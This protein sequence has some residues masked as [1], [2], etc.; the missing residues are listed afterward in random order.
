MWYSAVPCHCSSSTVEHGQ[1]VINSD[2]SS[3][4]TAILVS[5]RHL[6]QNIVVDG[7]NRKATCGQIQGD[8]EC[9]ELWCQLN[10]YITFGLG[11]RK[12]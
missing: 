7:R 11:L 5:L 6:A 1:P 4:D 2:F 3:N 8:Y 10:A 9:V 12:F